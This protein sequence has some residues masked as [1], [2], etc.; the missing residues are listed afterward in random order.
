MKKIILFIITILIL[1]IFIVIFSKVTITKLPIGDEARE[2]PSGVLEQFIINVQEIDTDEKDYR[3]EI[4]T[5]LVFV[6]HINK[7]INR[8]NIITLIE[9]IP[10]VEP[11]LTTD[12]DYYD[13]EFG[14]YRMSLYHN[15]LIIK[16]SIYYLTD[17]KVDQI[18]DILNKIEE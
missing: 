8:E 3:E 15:Y 10:E 13:V 4:G 1:L 6:Y 16:G 9:K 17:D 7:K 18:W 14:S 5:M 12:D 11:Y 2:I